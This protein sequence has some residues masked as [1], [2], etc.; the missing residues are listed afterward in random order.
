MEVEVIEG[1]AI[2]GATGSINVNL[3]EH[4]NVNAKQTMLHREMVQESAE[5]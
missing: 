4:L 5:Q 2:N 1:E 3:G